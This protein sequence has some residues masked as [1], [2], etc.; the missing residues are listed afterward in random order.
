[1]SANWSEQQLWKKY[2]TYGPPYDWTRTTSLQYCSLQ[3]LFIHEEMS[4]TQA[5]TPSW[6]SAMPSEWHL[7]S[8]SSAKDG[9]KDQSYAPDW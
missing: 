4:S 2:V 7:Y 9:R 8:V 5:K 3:L 6:R 1:M